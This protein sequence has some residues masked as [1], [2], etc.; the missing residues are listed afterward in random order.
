MLKFNNFLSLRKW[1]NSHFSLSYC[2]KFKGLSYV[3][4]DLGELYFY[5]W[6]DKLLKLFVNGRGR[7]GLP[8][9]DVSVFRIKG[10]TIKLYVR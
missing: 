8:L 3:L 5:H 10:K 1:F 6:I 7:Y 9:G 2:G 4:D